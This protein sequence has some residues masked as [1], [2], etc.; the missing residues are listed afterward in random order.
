MRIWLT[1]GALSGL[2]S[3]ALGAFA[4]HGLQSRVG[5]AEL[6]VFET[7]AR[8]QMYHALALLAVAWVAAQGGG[9]FA[10]IAGWAFVAGTILFSGSL[11]YLGLTGSRSLVLVTPVGGVAF[12]AGWLSLALAAWSLK[13]PGA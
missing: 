1:I 12:L 11:Y 2:F 5:P 3:V 4:A 9:T 6:A 13:T 7:G 8:Y 10:A